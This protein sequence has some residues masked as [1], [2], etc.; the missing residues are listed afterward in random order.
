MIT[1]ADLSGKPGQ[2]QDGH[3]IAFAS[4]RG[5]T[6]E[7]LANNEAG[8]NGVVGIS[9]YVMRADGTDVRQLVAGGADEVFP[10]D[11]R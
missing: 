10:T 4:D 9:L 3:W 7:Q 5:A 2:A 6:A 8:G 11:W 1:Q